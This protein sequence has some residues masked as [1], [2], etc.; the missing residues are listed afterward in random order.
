M[1][2]LHGAKGRVQAVAEDQIE[3]LGKAVVE[4]DV[5]VAEKSDTTAARA[6]TMSPAIVAAKRVT[7]SQIARRRTRRVESA[8][9]WAISKPCVR[10][11]MIERD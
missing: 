1:Q 10:R 6:A 7:S 3:Y 5:A 11:P 9:K 4:E 8:A 2:N